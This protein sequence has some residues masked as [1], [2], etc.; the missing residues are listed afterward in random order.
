MTPL[1]PRSHRHPAAPAQAPAALPQRSRP[2]RTRLGDRRGFA[3]AIV[4]WC[5]ALSVVV[6]L[7]VQTIAAQQASAGRE[8][9]AAVRA[10]WA[11]RSGVEA[12][13]ARLAAENEQAEPRPIADLLADLAS[14]SE[15]E[16]AGARFR[17][18]HG[19]RGVEVTGPADAHARINVNTLR[20]EDLTLLPLI[21][22]DL[23]AAVIDW[24]DPDD[25]AE[26]LGA[27]SGT[28][29]ALPSSYRPRNGP[30]RDIAELELVR[31]VTRDLLR[32]PDRSLTGVY[33]DARSRRGSTPEGWSW[34]LTASSV[35]PTL[36]ADGQERLDLASATPG[37]IADRLRVT[38]PQAQAI[39]SYAQVQGATREDFIRSTLTTLAR[40]AQPT[41]TATTGTT[42][43]PTTATQAPAVPA[44][45]NQQVADLYDLATV[46]PVVRGRPGKLNINSAPDEALEYL[47]VINT[48]ELRDAIIAYR[49]STGN[50]V[51]ALSELLALPGMSRQ[52]LADMAAQVDVRS[53][54]FEM[55]ST[56][57]DTVSGLRVELVAEV[58]RSTSPITVRKLLRR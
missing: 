34:L 13:I 23:A 41:T 20:S 38:E 49:T 48:P 56:G 46:G 14:V 9:L 3:T 15:G 55:V 28:Y 17:V 45:T 5:I 30:V 26:L 52:R 11:A 57:V 10:K 4:L 1:R 21:T 6:L 19:D 32:G 54:V 31:G 51:R 27:E 35:D 39:A 22:D 18:W 50:N 43:A 47:S 25:D 24:I 40:R 33:G 7:G 8:A 58:D 16:L 42:R 29:L 36:A 37:Q 44:L 53:A 2:G 12:V